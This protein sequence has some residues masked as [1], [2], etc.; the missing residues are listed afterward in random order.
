M[1]TQTRI[2]LRAI[3]SRRRLAQA[4]GFTLMEAMIGSVILAFV[5]CSIIAII[6]HCSLY[7]VDLRLRTRSSQVLQ[8]KLE[9]LRTKTWAQLQTYPPAFTDASDTNRTYA[10]KAT[11]VFYQNFGATVT[12]M[13]ATVSVTWTNRHSRIITNS[14]STL[15]G[16]G[17]IN[18]T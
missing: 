17:G 16:N 9:E 4:G 13:R 14:L 1:N 12:V 10:G 8:Q 2:Y 11:V 18:K 7:V 5:I 6:S 15:I 3:R